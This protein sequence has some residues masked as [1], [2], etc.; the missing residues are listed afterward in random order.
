MA[1]L[2]FGRVNGK[3]G[4]IK[5]VAWDEQGKQT[6][7]TLKVALKEG[8][9]LLRL[10]PDQPFVLRTDASEFAIGA[11]LE[12]EKDGQWVPVTFHSTKLAKSQLNWTT[13]EK[14]HMQ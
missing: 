10:E 6:F 1:Q 12:Q 9:E 13:R 5:L 4:S 3:E 14:R 11:V 7:E 2:Q 8:L